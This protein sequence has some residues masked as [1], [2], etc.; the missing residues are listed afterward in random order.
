MVRKRLLSN[1]DE[2]EEPPKKS[3]GFEF[4]EPV[5]R[6]EEDEAI[7]VPQGPAPSVRTED[8]A[9]PNWN[10]FMP[11]AKQTAKKS[12]TPKVPR[13]PKEKKPKKPKKTFTEVPAAEDRLQVWNIPLNA[14]ETE[15]VGGLQAAIAKCKTDRNYKIISAS[16]YMG[17]RR[18]VLKNYDK[19][20]EITKEDIQSAGSFGVHEVTNSYGS[21]DGRKGRKILCKND[22][23]FL[24][25]TPLIEAEKAGRPKAH[26]S[27]EGLVQPKGN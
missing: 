5:D 10:D 23:R 2:D 13:V 1:E 12:R 16:G 22:R 3:A 25:L 17:G 20:G 6:I 14:E 4:Q 24:N 11:G 18:L 7:P 26:L 9:L 19:V 21:T 15:P 27:R 8:Q